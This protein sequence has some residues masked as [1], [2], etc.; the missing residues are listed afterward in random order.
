M[1]I[2]DY[3]TSRLR[4]IRRC[5]AATFIVCLWLPLGSAA[6]GLVESGDLQR[7]LVGY[8][9]FAL[10]CSPAVF[11]F[12]LFLT[13]IESVGLRLLGRQRGFRITRDIAGTICSHASIGWVVSSVGGMVMVPAATVGLYMSISSGKAPSG[14]EQ[15]TSMRILHVLSM[16]TLAGG[17]LLMIGGFLF[18]ETLAWLGLFRCKY[19]NRMKPDAGTASG[20]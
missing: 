5:V 6:A 3:S 20:S 8:I 15:P 16:F 2:V 14:L 4:T 13:K 1:P 7:K 17:A 9:V 12:L 19:A 18:F 10:L 11:A